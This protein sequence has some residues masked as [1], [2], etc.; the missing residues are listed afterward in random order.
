MY[1]ATAQPSA[2]AASAP[3][4]A[5]ELRVLFICHSRALGGSELYLEQMAKRMAR[6]ATVRVVC[7]PDPVLDEWAARLEAAGAEIV[8][9]A[10][11]DRAGF[12]RLRREVRWASVVHL[13][14]ANRAGAYQ[15]LVTLACRLER[16]PL[17]CTH[18]L[19]R[20]AETLPLG[21]LGRR[22]RALALGTVYGAARRHIA[23]SADGLALLP[24]RTGLDARRTV[25][26]SNG[27]DLDRFVRPAPEAR[28]ALR[29]RL[30]GDAG[31]GVVAC[32]TVA[33]L[34]AQKGLDVLIDA[35]AI[36]RERG[37]TPR[38]R[39]FIVGDGELRADLEAQI[40]RLGVGDEVRLVGARPPDEVPEWL[41]SADL[42]VLPSHYEGMSLAVM[43]AMATGLPVVVTRVSGTAELVP[44]AE[45]G[46]VVEPGDADGLAGAVAVLAADPELRTLVGMRAGEHAKSF[47]W[48]ACFAKTNALLRGVAAGD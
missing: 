23:V 42:F 24:R 46:R 12:A 18:Q 33:R 15:V 14:L 31:D 40:A 44:D 26:I 43:E 5:A 34:S 3:D 17:V 10:L 8:R 38:A 47:S 30:L 48:D 28:A 4:R 32:C 27:V 37:A 20:E 39:F 1:N 29:R 7:R 35:A 16:R 6:E 9:I 13:T 36:L 22:F 25:Q 21:A 19:A 45:H 11:P 41:A 2:P